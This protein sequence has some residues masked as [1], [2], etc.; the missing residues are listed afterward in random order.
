[1]AAE[2]PA[3]AGHSAAVKGLKL[4]VLRAVRQ[5]VT[6]VEQPQPAR[7]GSLERGLI[8]PSKLPVRAG[9]GIKMR[10]PTCSFF[11]SSM[12]LTR[13]SCDAVTLNLLAIAAGLSPR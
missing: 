12:L 10:W 13:K 6:P 5:A 2:R 1:M 8:P 7:T 9:Y 11:G 3:N 4:Y